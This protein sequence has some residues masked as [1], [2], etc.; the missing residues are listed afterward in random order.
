MTNTVYAVPCDEDA[1]GT[2]THLVLTTIKQWSDEFTPGRVDP[3]DALNALLLSATL[4]IESHPEAEERDRL[5]ATARHYLRHN[6]TGNEREIAKMQR[7]LERLTKL[8][9]GK[10][11]GNA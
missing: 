9:T 6:M 2:L 8:Q 7:T 10:T 3:D 11:A 4:V 5:V 1:V